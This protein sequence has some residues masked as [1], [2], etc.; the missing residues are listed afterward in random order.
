QE[1]QHVR[2]LWEHTRRFQ[3]A[4]RDLG[5]D[6]GTTATPITPV[7]VGESHLARRF[8]E[9]LFE[10]GVFALPILYPMVAKDRARLRTIM[11]ASLTD[12]DLDFAIRQFET[13]GRE[14]K[15]L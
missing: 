11:N 15:I 12:E 4:M 6:L 5:F 13:A 10:L 2:R 3:K 9:R 1:P 7:I 8:S 14:L